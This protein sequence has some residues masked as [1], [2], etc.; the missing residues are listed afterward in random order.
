MVKTCFKNILETSTVSLA[1][2]TEDA[3]YPLY[4]LYDRNI[5]R[6]FRPAAAGTLEIKVDQGASN[7]LRVDRVLLPA[8]HDLGGGS[9][10][11]RR[12]DDDISY[13]PV[14][15][16]S[17]EFEAPTE[18]DLLAGGDGAKGGGWNVLNSV[19]AAAL[20]INISNAGN[21]T[22][23]TPASPA[24]AWYSSSS[25][26]F[27]YKEVTGDFDVE[28]RASHNAGRASEGPLLCV[29]KDGDDFLFVGSVFTTALQAFWRNCVNG[30]Q[31]SGS[32]AAN[33]PC[34][35]I[36]RV[37]NVFT[38]Y[39]KASAGGAWVERAQY[40]RD[41]FGPTAQ[42][43]LGVYD[44]S[45]SD[46]LAARFDYMRFKPVDGGFHTKEWEPV[47]ARY[48]R[49][50]LEGAASVPSIPEIFLSSTY[51]WERNPARPTGALDDEF[52][53]EN[54]A[55]AGGQDRFLVHGPPKRRRS[56]HMPRCGAAQ[57]GNLLAL[58]AE[59]AGSRPFWLQDH[60]GRWIYGKLRAPLALREVAHGAWS[61]DFDFLEVLP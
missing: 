41:D 23:D 45:A 10:A 22:M 4:R 46:M 60:E 38:L 56:Y 37:G 40:T 35:R 29:R 59:W 20:D 32:A 31:S 25:G 58:N 3:N 11:V 39:T 21:L 54:A 44:T 34:L 47:A 6:P 7:I 12:S 19:C 14:V 26:V 30:S 1:A 49:I 18:Q 55:T 2:G 8:G 27:V 42:V 61:F 43:G 52:N 9:L 5:G 15:S 17:D 36:R 53:V 16:D 13:L 48:W 24:N 57:K 51:E 50:T 28:T 33:H